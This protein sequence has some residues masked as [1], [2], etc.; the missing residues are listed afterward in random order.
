MTYVEEITYVDP[1]R[2]FAGVAGE[3]FSLLFDSALPSA[4]LGRYSYIAALPRRTLTARH[5]AV[6]VDGRTVDG[7]PFVV[8]QDELARTPRLTLSGLP[9]FQG[10]AAG[11]F[12]YDLCNH[13]ETLPEPATD[14]M[15]FD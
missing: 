14:D 11:A 3:R 1:A 2:A 12:G 13:L 7:D 8:L 15:D 4:R 6:T 10:G 5:R 9:A